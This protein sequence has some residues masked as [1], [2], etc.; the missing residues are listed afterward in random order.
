MGASIGGDDS[1]AWAIEHGA[2]WERVPGPRGTI[3]S[4]PT[5]QHSVNLEETRGFCEG[6]DPINTDEKNFQITIKI[7]VDPEKRTVFLTSLANAT[8]DIT[9]N[10]VAVTFVLPIVARDHDQITVDWAF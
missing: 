5:S 3:Y 7:P 4:K 10:S 1:V 9:A 2:G 8:K 6:R